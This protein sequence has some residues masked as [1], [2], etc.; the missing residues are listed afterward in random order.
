MLPHVKEH[1]AAFADGEEMP[2]NPDTGRTAPPVGKPALDGSGHPTATPR[3]PHRAVVPFHRAR[4]SHRIA[5]L[6]SG[7][8][9]TKCRSEL[10]QI[11]QVIHLIHCQFHVV[12][13]VGRDEVG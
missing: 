6:R 4:I 1:M 7:Y 9:I 12:L 5:K 11:G 3:L 2:F 13:M 8:P 10:C